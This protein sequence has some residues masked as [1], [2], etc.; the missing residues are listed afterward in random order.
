[1]AHLVR[2]QHRLSMD[3]GFEAGADIDLHIGRAFER[4]LVIHEM[5]AIGEQVLAGE[6]SDNTRRFQRGGSV[7]AADARMRMMRADHPGISRVRQP[8]I[9]DVNTLPGQ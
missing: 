1:M 8:H 4:R 5:E 9:G 6:D 3:K 2:R 7:D